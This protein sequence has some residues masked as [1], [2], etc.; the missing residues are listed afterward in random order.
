ML[1]FY[2]FL[3]L[4]SHSSFAQESTRSFVNEE[5]VSLGGKWNH[6]QLTVRATGDPAKLLVGQKVWDDFVMTVEVKAGNHCQAG[7]IF[8]V[9]NAGSKI[10]EYDGYYIGI[11]A[12]RDSIIWGAA[13]HNWNEIAQ[14][15]SK[16]E[17]E[18]WYTIRVIARGN[19]FQ[20]WVGN[21]P[22]NVNRFPTFDGIDH[23]FQSGRVGLRALG[24][25][26]EF[27]NLT[28]N[29]PNPIPP[30]RSYTNP[31]QA[32]VADPAILKHNNTY[33]A[34]CTHSAD[35]PLM[36]RGIRLYSSQNLVQ[37]QDHGF[38]ITEKQSWGTSRFWA[39]DIIE[40]QNQFYLYY[41]T[42]TRI[43]VAKSR[44]PTGPFKELPQSPMLPETV[45]I[46]AHVF[47]DNGK[48]YFYYVRFNQGNEIWG[49]ELN[50]DMVSL[51]PNSLKRMIQADQ[52]W[53]RNQAAIAEGPAVLKHKDLYY[54]TYSGSHFES[55]HYA[56]GYATSK[57]PLGPWTKHPY[58]PIMK[59]TAYA[60]GT[61]HHC[62][63][64]SP[65]G[66]ELF[67]VYHRHHD[68]TNTEPRQMAIDRVQFIPQPIGP[69]ILEI[70]GPTSSPQPI[71]SGAD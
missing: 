26:A 19:Q 40:H 64:T 41:A 14:K 31:V 51:K 13:N 61:A 7:V 12:A 21:D 15:V 2:T 24:G 36:K 67:I 42:D 4:I 28:I 66:E 25:D 52:P 17:A 3:L 50:D 16:I 38:V 32:N 49:G 68:L 44:H 8:R 35:H 71:P 46:D 43:C 65:D 39:P 22:L 30:R 47:Q 6:N 18:Q 20:A 62:F 48:A 34:Y 60:H 70:H 58:N 57:S 53:E 45:R 29:A 54:L 37:W 23:R 59:S 56:V 9:N 63:T 5:L 10:D 11:D 55:P 1:L 27:R 33:Y 69:D